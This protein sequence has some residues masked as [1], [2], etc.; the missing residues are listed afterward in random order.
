MLHARGATLAD[1]ACSGLVLLLSKPRTA[2]NQQNDDHSCG[3]AMAIQCHMQ[4]Q[5]VTCC[6]AMRR[7]HEYNAMAEQA[8]TA[9]EGD[10]C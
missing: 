2:H 7:G 6:D 9:T 10:L 5:Q 4:F 3:I 8:T 1:A